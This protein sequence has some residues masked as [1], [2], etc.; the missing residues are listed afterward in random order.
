VAILSFLF[1]WPTSGGG[2][3]HTVELAKFL[4]RA[5]YNVAHWYARYAPWHIGAV[6]NRVF[7]SQA[8][9]F[10]EPTW[11]VPAIQARFRQ[12]VEGFQP[13]Y[14]LITDTW[15]MKPIL[16][17][18]V[19]GFATLLR[20]Q[21]L[22]CLCPLNN[23]RLLA[24]GPDRFAQCPKHQLA[25][26][27]DCCTCLGMRAKQSGWLH[28]VERHLAGVGTP[29]YQDKLRRALVEAE[30]VLVLNPLT[31]AMLSSYARRVVVVPWGMDAA[32][33]PWPWPGEPAPVPD[34]PV[35]TIFQAGVISEYMKGFPILHAA[36]ARLWQ[37]R[38]D[39][40]LVAT[41]DPAGRIDVMTRLTGWVSQAD[42]PRYYHDADIIAVPTIA[43]EGLSRTSVEAMAAARPV[44]ASRIGGLPYTVADG[45]TGFLCEAGDPGDLASKLETLLADADLRR[46][47]GLAARRRFEEQFTWE[48]VIDKYYRPLLTAKRN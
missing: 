15:N 6:K 47:M 16:A 5:G 7:P 9:E 35:K 31:E 19:R 33:F 38:Q 48:V 12:V 20:F 44:V 37:K 3:I 17:E 29:E 40:Q 14:V 30:A 41:G 21:A 18:A 8:L 22:E 26:P 23:V 10:D 42:L 39:F 45:A 27:D 4:Q 2:N 24:E 13:D 36:C 11:N 28:Q 25:T 43:Q 32:R 34:R 1:T 46:R